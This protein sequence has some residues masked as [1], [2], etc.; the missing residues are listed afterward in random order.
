MATAPAALQV[1]IFRNFRNR[2][3][4]CKKAL[5]ISKKLFRCRV[6]I[7]HFLFFSRV[8][9]VVPEAAPPVGRTFVKDKEKTKLDRERRAQVR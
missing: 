1:L 5:P 2:H 7:L 3:S 4:A 8:A 6:Q 9:D